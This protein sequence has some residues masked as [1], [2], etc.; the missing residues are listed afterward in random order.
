MNT[1]KLVVMIK[2]FPFLGSILT[3]KEGN[4]Y[5]CSP[6]T[7]EAAIRVYRVLWR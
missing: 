3:Q 2:E 1:Y 5:F 7:K 6:E 4:N